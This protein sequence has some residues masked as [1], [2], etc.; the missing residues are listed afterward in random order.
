M[1][2][3]RVEEDKPSLFECTDLHKRDKS[4]RCI[5][6][7]CYNMDAKGKIQIKLINR[8]EIKMG[9]V[10]NIVIIF[11]GASSEYAVSLQSAYAVICNIDR[12][13]YNPVTVGI[14]QEG[15]WFYFSGEIDKIQKDTW[16]NEM[17]CVPVVLSPDR[18]W[19][20]LIV[21]YEKNNEIKI[22]SIPIDAVFPVLHGRN[23]ED[24]TVQGIVELAGI[25]LIGCGTLS[26]SLCMD[27]DR[28][29]RLV[30][31]SGIR[32]P[33]GMVLMDNT[34][35]NKACDFIKNIG[36]PV[37]VKPVKAGS[38]FGITKVID[39]EQLTLAIASAFKY[40]NRVILEEAI[41]GFE[42]GCAVCGY[43]SLIVGEIDEIELNEANN[44]E[45]FF[46][47]TE[48]YTLKTSAIYVPARIPAEKA[49]EIKEI[50]K[51]I[52]QVLDCAGFARVD[53]FLT[54]E[55]EI[56]F[57]EVNTIPGF[58]EHSRYPGMMRAAGYGFTKI[59]NRIIEQV[60]E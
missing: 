8:G 25:P 2:G 48:K 20:R 29:H 60:F 18:T 12:Q 32:V 1:P 6:V 52:Y 35:V 24:G 19:H 47:F 5:H 3:A 28:A 41:D 14:T 38:S 33:H 26:S 17:D 11:G 54:P 56:V 15:N 58:T 39:M 34:A 42:V 44:S 53:M 21:L 23:G 43:D 22:E 57:N 7:E 37:F 4:L 50:A 46:D 9:N 16:Y 27:K 31:L 10:K 36:L 40:D 30:E 55:G 49:Q 51:R 45:G 59:V 13:K